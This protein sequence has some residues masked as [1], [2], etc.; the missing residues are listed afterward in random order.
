MKTEQSDHLKTIEIA[1]LSLMIIALPS[2]EAP[3]NIFLVFYVLLASIRWIETKNYEWGYW[4]SIFS[5]LILTNIICTY[6]AGI[7]FHDEWKGFGV[8]LTMLCPGW[9]ISK[10]NY[11]L[12]EI[13]R[14]YYIIILSTIPPLLFG[15]WNLLIS[16]TKGQLELHSVGHVNHSAIYLLVIFG[17]SLTWF[18]SDLKFKSNVQKFLLLL[19]VSLFFYGLIIGQSRGAFGVAFALAF[20]IV[21]FSKKSLTTKIIFYVTLIL[22]IPTLFLTHSNIAIKQ[23]SYQNGNNIMADRTRIWNAAT[24][25][26]RTYPFFGIGMFNWSQIKMEDL[27]LSV[28]KRNEK[29]K[30]E[31]YML[32]FGHA[33]SIYFS[34]LVEKGLVGFSMLIFLMLMW[35]RELIRN[36]PKIKNN[37]YFLFWGGAASAWAGIFGVGLVNSTFNHEHGILACMLL[38]LYLSSNK[39]INQKNFNKLNK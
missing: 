23:L 24:E 5:I 29:F 6:F 25:T 10:A 37:S 11:S 18:L 14:I 1:F 19:V 17:A 26:A 13:K 3:K 28:E 30:K 15:I 12:K 35:L 2:L 31:N 38:G 7:P 27:R 21:F 20:L 39:L 9:L 34:T 8:S 33:H 22:L 32:Q 4:D 16:K 36:Y